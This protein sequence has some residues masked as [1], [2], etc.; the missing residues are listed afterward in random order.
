MIGS[1]SAMT[2]VPPWH[3]VSPQRQRRVHPAPSAGRSSRQSCRRS[4][5]RCYSQSR[6]CQQENVIHSSRNMLHT[7]CS[8]EADD[9]QQQGE[10]R[11]TSAA[12]SLRQPVRGLQP[13]CAIVHCNSANHHQNIPYELKATIRRCCGLGTPA[14]RRPVAP[15]RRRQSQ[16]HHNR[17][18]LVG[19]QACIDPLSTTVVRPNPARPSG[20]GLACLTASVRC[21]MLGR[22]GHCWTSSS[23]WQWRAR[24]AASCRM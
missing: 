11:P 19:K 18:R 2:T 22:V 16:R 4:T 20:P 9:P 8:A 10:D 12:P 6:P 5:T 23:G 3:S 13:A 21:L 1:P 24:S 7:P 17:H 14:L 15:V